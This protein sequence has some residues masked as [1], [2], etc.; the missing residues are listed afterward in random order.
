MDTSSPAM[1]NP[2]GQTSI[3]GTARLVPATFYIAITPLSGRTADRR[4]AC[5]AVSSRCY[6]ACLRAVG[7]VAA[8]LFLVDG[9][10]VKRRLGL[11]APDD[12]QPEAFAAPDDAIGEDA[13]VVVAASDHVEVQFLTGAKRHAV[14][15]PPRPSAV[16][17]DVLDDLYR[18]VGVPVLSEPI[19]VGIALLI[20]CFGF[21]GAGIG[22]WERSAVSFELFDQRA[23]EGHDTAVVEFGGLRQEPG[24]PRDVD[25]CDHPRARADG[26]SVWERGL[27]VCRADTRR[28]VH[29]IVQRQLDQLP[30]SA[31]DRPQDDTLSVLLLSHRCPA[32]LD[33]GLG[34]QPGEQ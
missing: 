15:D 4:F 18:L 14:V 23:E 20:A 11:E 33:L 7:R 30:G 1:A 24:S 31:L 29:Q 12:P 3:T 9:Q 17:D 10:D 22:A 21:R 5:A 19:P 34:L 8:C 28:L 26:R 32:D 2:E 27:L 16:A 13:R 25:E 6:G